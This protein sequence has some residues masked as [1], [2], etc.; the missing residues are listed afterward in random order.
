[1]N[2]LLQAGTQLVILPLLVLDAQLL[3]EIHKVLVP[4]L[5]VKIGSQVAHAPRS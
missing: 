4:E 1:V 3:E 2:I 5:F